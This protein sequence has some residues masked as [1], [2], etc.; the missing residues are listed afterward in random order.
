[1]LNIFFTFFPLYS[2]IFVDINQ[3]DKNFIGISNKPINTTKY[4][5]RSNK[6]YIY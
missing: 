2:F 5:L 3:V 6:F 4:V 1:M